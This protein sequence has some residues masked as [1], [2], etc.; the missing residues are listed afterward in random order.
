MRFPYQQVCLGTKL[1]PRRTRSP[2]PAC[3]ALWVEAAFLSG[4]CHFPFASQDGALTCWCLAC[5]QGITREGAQRRRLL[6]SWQAAGQGGFVPFFPRWQPGS[7][8]HFIAAVSLNASEAESLQ[9]SGRSLYHS[10]LLWHAFK[11][12]FSRANNPDVLLN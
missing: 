2:H 12:N 7:D 4:H 1:N 9:M 8:F 11:A 6:L 5:S 10:V 3:L